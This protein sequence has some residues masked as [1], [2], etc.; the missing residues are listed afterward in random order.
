MA[1]RARTKRQ[2]LPPAIPPALNAT[3]LQAQSKVVETGKRVM[4]RGLM[5]YGTVAFGDKQV[6]HGAPLEVPPGF[7]TQVPYNSAINST[8]IQQ[9][10]A[11]PV[12]TFY[13]AMVSDPVVYSCMLYMITTII[14]R[15]GD[16]TNPDKE[17]EKVIRD[18]LNRVGKIKLLQALLTSL[19]AGFAAIKLNW[20][21]IDGYTTVRNIL[22]LPPD[23]IMLAV[24]PEG[25]LDPNFGVMQYYYNI[26]SAWNQNQKAFSSWGNAPLAAFATNMS[27]QRQVSFNPMFLSALPEEWRILHTFNPT[28]LAG[29][30]WGNS[31]IQSIFPSIVDKNNL[32]FKIQV[33]ATFKAAPLVWITTDT[34]TQVE[35]PNGNTIS[36]AQN[37]QNTIADGADTGFIITE[38]LG[39]VKL[40][41]INNT[42]N[43]DEMANLVNMYNNEIR[44]GLCTPNLVGNSGS[45]ANAMAN[46]QANDVIINNITLHLID[47]VER[48]FVKP[49]LD[50]A[51]YGKQGSLG[52]ASPEDRTY[53]RFELLD[54][55]LND[56]AIWGNLLLNAKNLGIMDPQSLDDLN[57]M[58][59]KL[60]MTE[61]D[62]LNED[63]VYGMM[64]L[65][66]EGNADMRANLAKTKEELK[67]PYS[68]GLERVKKN[69]YGDEAAA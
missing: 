52:A 15:I 39:S 36:Q 48:Q 53:G 2:Y 25:E 5:N 40:E 8:I 11:V 62:K 41:T 69:H 1:K 26:N 61:V 18:A 64:G 21:Y 32:R 3:D 20:D 63:L 54:N 34:Q 37:V 35:L 45:Y 10:S 22:V 6:N 46:S 7:A 24:T 30:W 51:I 16:Y 56:K 31:M 17:C 55:S 68:G 49:I 4:Y 57:F 59:K 12:T 47:T 66:N 23:S 29:N 60:G 33:G 43:L 42:A 44:S 65:L 14:S 38:G 28:G 13:Q 58:R 50:N 9:S 67:E 19:W 27:P